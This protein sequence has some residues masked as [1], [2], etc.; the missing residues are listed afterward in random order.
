MKKEDR[1]N[2]LIKE[3]MQSVLKEGEITDGDVFEL[4]DDART[5]LQDA[6]SNFYIKMPQVYQ[7]LYAAELESI[8]NHVNSAV[9]ETQ[10]LAAKIHQQTGK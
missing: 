4:L 7:G 5:S 1:V 6:Q 3:S 2:K 10:A 9:S 8:Y